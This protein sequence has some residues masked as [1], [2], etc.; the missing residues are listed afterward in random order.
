MPG[1][2]TSE[3]RICYLVTIRKHQVLDYVDVTD[4]DSV[5]FQIFEVSNLALDT[6]ADELDTHNHLHRHMLCK[7][8]KSFKYK[9][10]TSL[11]GFK[12][13]YDTV[14]K[15]DEEKVRKYIHKNWDQCHIQCALAHDNQYNL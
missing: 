3:A 6:Y 15:G 2:P 8:K 14:A 10:F 11:S 13:Q 5:A 4:L 7:I 9:P 1:G 12:V